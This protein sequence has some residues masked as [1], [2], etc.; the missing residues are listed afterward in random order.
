MEPE[1]PHTLT[2]LYRPDP[3]SAWKAIATGVTEDKAFAAM[4]AH[5]ISGDY[6]FSRFG[7]HEAAGVNR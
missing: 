2:L 3:R 5:G 4:R 7:R 6:W 1:L